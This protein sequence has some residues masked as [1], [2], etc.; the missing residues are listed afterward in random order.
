MGVTPVPYGEWVER[1]E[2]GDSPEWMRGMRAYVPHPLPSDFI[3]PTETHRVQA[4]AEHTLGELNER[5]RG[6]PDHAMFEL[7]TRLREV[8]SA[9]EM[10][11]TSADFSEAWMTSLLLT[12]AA[13]GVGEPEEVLLERAPMGRL[14]QAVEHGAARLAQGGPFDAELIRQVGEKLTGGDP[15]MAESGLRTGQSWLASRKGGQPRILTVPPGARLHSALAQWSAW[16]DAP[17]SLPRVGKISLGHLHL[18]LLDPYP[19]AGPY[20]TSI[21]DASA[22]VRTGLLRDH[23]LALSTWLDE[24]EQE[25]HARIRAVVDGGPI[26]DWILFFAG[27]VRAQASAQLLLIDQLNALRQSLLE[28][29]KGSPTVQRVVSGLITA[30]VTSNRALETIYGMANRTA[31]QVTRHLVQVGI[32][33]IVDG[34]SY[35]KVFV[36]QPVLD[37][38]ALQVPAAPSSDRHAFFPPAN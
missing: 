26:E 27:A 10:A 7:S 31:T 8:Q 22:M 12:R 3:L 1:S 30:P 23:V 37:L 15:D 19:G 5:T 14:L 38:Y 34:K 18:V 4:M 17:H 21:Y 20:L 16:I 36:C 29:A 9:A 24:H 2:T 35:N 6:L 13:E 28:Q 11:G 33:E 32:L 25:Y